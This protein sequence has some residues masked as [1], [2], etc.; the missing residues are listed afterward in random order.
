MLHSL[1]FVSFVGNWYKEYTH[2]LV[3]ETTFVYFERRCLLN[4]GVTS[5]GALKGWG[6]GV[7]FSSLKWRYP[8][9]TSV[10][11]SLALLLWNYFSSSNKALFNIPEW[12]SGKNLLVTNTFF[13]K[14]NYSM[15]S[16]WKLSYLC[17]LVTL[18]L[19]L[20]TY[21]KGF[22]VQKYTLF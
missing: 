9:L 20:K 5:K 7:K 22:L 19:L 17:T 4:R 16:V 1:L 6:G 11:R 8:R 13:P 10:L 15:I 3:L 12:D 2:F 14:K 18:T 21:A